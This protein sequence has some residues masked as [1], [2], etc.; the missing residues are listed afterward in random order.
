MNISPL[1]IYLWQLADNLLRTLQTLTI[2]TG[3]SFLIAAIVT[4]IILGE[5]HD[6]GDKALK[7]ACRFLAAV[8]ALFILFLT[9]FTFTP[10][11]KTIAMMIVVP[12][13]ANS[14]I[15]QKDV[16]DLYNMAVQAAKDSLTAKKP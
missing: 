10:T 15:I 8:F 1:T 3:V 14:K 9:A 2:L 7:I 6:W 11:S 5:T 12:E 13:I 16:P 4:I